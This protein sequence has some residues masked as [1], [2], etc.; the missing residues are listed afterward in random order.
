M[1]NDN[2]TQML[3]GPPIADPNKTIMGAGPSL[4]TTVTIKP[5][6]CPVCKSFNPPGTM[7]CTDCGLIFEKALDEDAFGAPTVRLPCLV[8]PSG[9]E[10][11]LRNGE[12]VIG[13]QGDILVEDTRVSR[14]HASVVLQG[15]TATVTDLGSTNGTK[16][17]GT[18]VAAGGVS[19]E[20]GAVIS[21]GGYELRLSIP[22]EENKTQAA[23]S[24][25][26]AALTVAPT[27]QSAVAWLVIDEEERALE[28]GRYTFGRRTDNDVVVS[29][30]FVS[31]RHGLFEVDDT[32]VYLTDTGSTNGTV[33]NDA[34]IAV[35]Q[36][37]QL[38]K[39]DVIKLGERTIRIRFKE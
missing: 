34:K 36:R 8:D 27:V 31:G 16:V 13:R 37:T 12:N 24:G 14:R 25:R 18:P 28:P 15:G 32:G 20:N 5:V 10:H 4:N 29:D 9:K 30:P 19:I 1:A 21:L 2:R 35:N 7:Y 39:D 33:L 26:T 6:Q 23:L 17:G 22:G 38:R 3:G 11:Q